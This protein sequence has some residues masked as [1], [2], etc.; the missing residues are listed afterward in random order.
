[1]IIRVGVVLR[2]TVGDD[3]DWCVDSL[4]G[5]SRQSQV[6]CDWSVDVLSLWSLSW[7]VGDLN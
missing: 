6:D 1:M 7:L 3:I 4:S 2:G 5:G